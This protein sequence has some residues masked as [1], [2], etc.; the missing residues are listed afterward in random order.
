LGDRSRLRCSRRSAL[1]LRPP[2]HAS[3]RPA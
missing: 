3:S 1:L 2:A